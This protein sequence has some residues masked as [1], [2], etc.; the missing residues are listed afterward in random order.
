MDDLMAILL[1]AL[2]VLVVILAYRNSAKQDELRRV[3]ESVPKMARQLFDEWLKAHGDALRAQQSEVAK[4]EA[5]LQLQSWKAD[6]ELQIR[7]DA[8]QRSHAVILGKVTEHVVPFL[9]SFGFNP[10]DARFIGSPVDLLVFDGLDEG[11]LREIVFIEVKTG[12]SASLTSRE[13]QIRDA[14]QGQRVTWREMRVE[15]TATP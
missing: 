15:K 5:E 3:T 10:K 2:L 14:I 8:I 12:A 13:R 4:R 6:T 1:L 9:P 7:N 11:N